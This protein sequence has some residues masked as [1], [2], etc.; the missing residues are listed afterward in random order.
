MHE[1]ACKAPVE[2][3][4]QRWRWP[5]DASVYDRTAS[6]YPHE[7]GELARLVRRNRFGCW[8]QSAQENL[9]RLRTPVYDVLKIIEARP[10]HWCTATTVLLLDMHH[11]QTSF[12]GWTDSQWIETIGTSPSA[13]CARHSLID[14][15]VRPYLAAVAYLLERFQ[16]ISALG[17][18]NHVNL[19]RHVF[20]A[21]RVNAA[22][23]QVVDMTTAWGFGKCVAGDLRTTIGVLV[24][25][26]RSPNLRDITVTFLEQQRRLAANSRRSASILNLSRVLLTLGLTGS[27]LPFLPE[28]NKPKPV[29]DVRKGVSP[30]W[31]QWVERWRATSTLQP[32]TRRV[33]C[34]YLFKAGRW[35]AIVHPECSSPGAWT[36]EIAADWVA[37][38]CRMKVGDWMQADAKYQRSRIGKPLGAATRGTHLSSVSAFFRDCQEWEWIPRRFDPRRC[39]GIPR[40]VRALLAPNPRIIADDVW[41]KLLWAGLNLAASDLPVKPKQKCHYYSLEMVK[42]VTIVWLFCGLRM[43][44]IRRLQV[45]C[46]LSSKAPD[47]PVAVCTVAVPANKTTPAFTKPVDQL[48]GEAVKT[49]E[50]VRPPQ[51]LAL[52]EK[53][54]ELVDF[55]FMFRG[56]KIAERYINATLIPILCQKAGIPNADATGNITSHRARSTIASQLFNSKEPMSLFELQKWLGH[57]WAYSTEYYLRTSATKLADSYRNAEYFARNI[58]AIEVL[59][60]R[61]VVLNGKANREPWRYYDLGHGYCS[62]DFFDQCPHRMACAKCS[63]YI[64]KNTT[65]SLL[66][67]GKANLLRMRQEIPLKEAE[68]AAI[69]D[70]VAAFDK[71][72]TQLADVP[73]PSGPTPR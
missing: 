31:V 6:L 38:V 67:E 43:D 4:T 73:T 5:I 24:L 2:E 26:N 41:A 46:V 66:L 48:V 30:E 15:T 35:L 28:T 65:Q 16:E 42:A 11:R 8:S 69:D 36:R 3:A 60:D 27:A 17:T 61:D 49:W 34:Q 50:A 22:I 29:G 55:L 33:C 63:F 72:L 21:A 56:R 9:S 59:I 20:S 54:G 40:S 58:R 70:G 10:G 53:T 18:I 37:A 14:D 45:G 44:E 12:W 57:K 52:D 19:A 71:L 25:A 32:K 51:P 7:T 23:R 47:S 64:P 68:L 13:F 39:F 1:V 62:Y